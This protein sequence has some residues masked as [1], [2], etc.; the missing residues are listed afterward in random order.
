LFCIFFFSSFFMICNFDFFYRVISLLFGTCVSA[1]WFTNYD[2][3]IRKST[4][5][6]YARTNLWFAGTLVNYVTMPSPIRVLV[7]ILLH[8]TFLEL[9]SLCSSFHFFCDS[10]FYSVVLKEWV[11]EYS[12]VFCFCAKKM[13]TQ[14]SANEFLYFW[15]LHFF[16]VLF[17]FSRTLLIHSIF[18]YI[19]KASLDFTFF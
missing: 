18:I 3:P 4:A 12:V 7:F 8:Q 6:R 19:F 11:S 17:S 10:Q 13:E 5:N 2:E 9:S 14:R 1:N 15:N 16:H